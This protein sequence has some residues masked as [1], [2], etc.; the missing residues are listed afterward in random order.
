M[1][2]RP[3]VHPLHVTIVSGNPK[4]INGLEDYLRAAG[5]TVQSTRLLEK[6]LEL[7]P[8]FAT[9]IVLFPDDFPSDAVFRALAALRSQRSHAVPILVTREP[10]RFQALPSLDQRAA[11]VVVP[12]PAWGWTI[13]D[14]IRARLGLE[15]QRK[16]HHDDQE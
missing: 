11:P 2:P 15:T 7:V 3:W 10:R 9:A 12:K 4:T 6:A 8:V 16:K 1:P 14:A 13:L 5:V